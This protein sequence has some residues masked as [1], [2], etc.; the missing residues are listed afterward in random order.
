MG[1]DLYLCAHPRCHR[2]THPPDQSEQHDL[3]IPL[4]GL[5]FRNTTS[6]RQHTNKYLFITP[7]IMKSTDFNDLQG[8]SETALGRVSPE[9]PEDRVQLPTRADPNACMLKR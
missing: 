8:A 9:E 7:T 6:R 4:V 1:S 5:A 3:C 2:G